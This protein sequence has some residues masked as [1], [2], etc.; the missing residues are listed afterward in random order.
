MTALELANLPLVGREGLEDLRGLSAVPDLVQTVDST[1]C[2]G[3][4]SHLCSHLRICFHTNAKA[5]LPCKA[6]QV[7]AQKDVPCLR[8]LLRDGR[9]EPEIGPEVPRALLVMLRYN[10]RPKCGALGIPIVVVVLLLSL[11]P[12]LQFC[13]VCQTVVADKF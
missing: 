10:L 3:R 11:T 12:K 13:Q 4:P 2:H 6:A 7:A 5:K 8:Y 1:A 9:R